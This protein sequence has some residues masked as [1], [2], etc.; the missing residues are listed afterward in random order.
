M[1]P[2]EF[3][4]IEILGNNVITVPY[5]EV[6]IIYLDESEPVV[7]NAR[8]VQESSVRKESNELSDFYFESN[9]ELLLNIGV[10]KVYGLPDLGFGTPTVLNQDVAG[11]FYSANGIGFKGQFFAGIGPG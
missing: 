6:R 1:K 2:G 8:V 4:K 10:G 3:F 9:N 5:L 7:N 11:G